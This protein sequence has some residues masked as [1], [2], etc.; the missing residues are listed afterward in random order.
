MK[1]AHTKSGL[2]LAFTQEEANQLP[3]PMSVHINAKPDAPGA[4][5]LT[6]RPAE[7]GLPTYRLTTA[8]SSGVGYVG[9]ITARPVP[10]LALFGTEVLPLKKVGIC[11]VAPR[12]KM[13]AIIRCKK[14]RSA[15]DPTAPKTPSD[16][17]PAARRWMSLDQAV[18]AINK[19]KDE[20]R[21]A[22][23][24]EVTDRGHL[25]ALMQFGKR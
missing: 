22:L 7:K 12:P 4:A 18:D 20:L 1:I 11:L 9:R 15:A 5:F 10:G 2:H 16:R 6:L 23:V 14:R 3:V 21:H 25:R 24:L 13:E 17:P 19:Y 8:T